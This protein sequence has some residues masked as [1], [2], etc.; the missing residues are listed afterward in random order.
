MYVHRPAEL[1]HEEPVGEEVQP[2]VGLSPVPRLAVVAVDHLRATGRNRVA[3][4][5]HASAGFVDATAG[6]NVAFAV[7]MPGPAR[8]RAPNPALT[9]A[10]QR[11]K[12]KALRPSGIE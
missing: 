10:R 5:L 1:P 4:V 2:L 9:A 11:A 6:R 12:M 8:A 3:R 7:Q